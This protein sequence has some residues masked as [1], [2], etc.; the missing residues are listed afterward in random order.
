LRE[1]PIISQQPTVNEPLNNTRFVNVVKPSTTSSATAPVIRII[2][3]QNLDSRQERFLA[4]L[5]AL[6]APSPKV[7]TASIIP[8]VTQVI[9][10]NDEKS[11][12]GQDADLNAPVLLPRM[13]VEAAQKA[14]VPAAQPTNYQFLPYYQ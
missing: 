7:P 11:D 14:S 5:D 8:A 2:G 12:G 9:E 4:A 6:D 13:I 10:E 3:T 1:E